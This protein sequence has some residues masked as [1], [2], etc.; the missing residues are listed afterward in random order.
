MRRIK[1]PKVWHVLHI[2]DRVGNIGWKK[3]WNCFDHIEIDLLRCNLFSINTVITFTWTA[4]DLN[5]HVLKVIGL[6]VTLQNHWLQADWT[7]KLTLFA[8]FKSVV[9]LQSLIVTLAWV[10][11]PFAKF[12]AVHHLYRCFYLLWS[13]S[14]P[15]YMKCLNFADLWRHVLNRQHET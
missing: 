2:V 10:E 6:H 13:F 7:Q 5:L 12:P 1:C 9:N 15:R 8:P 11:A 4:I 3:A 14:R